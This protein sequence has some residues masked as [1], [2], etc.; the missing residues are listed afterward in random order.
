MLGDDATRALT[1]ELYDRSGGNPLFLEELAELVGCGGEPLQLPDSLRALVAARLDE[2]PVDQR[3]MLDNAAVLGSSGSYGGAGEFGQA[4]GQNAAARFSTRSPT[5]GCWR[6]TAVGG[7]SARP[8]SARSRTTPSPRPTVLVATS[9]WPR[10][11][12]TRHT[13]RGGPTCWPTTGRRRRS[14]PASSA[15]ASRASPATWSTRRCRRCWR[16]RPTTS[17]VSTPAPPSSRWRGRSR[18]ATASSTGPTRRSLVLTRAAAWVELRQFPEAEAD[19]QAVVDEAEAEGDRGCLA[20]ARAVRAEI[21]RLTG[22]YEDART[23]LAAAA[24]LLEDLGARHELAGV[25]RAWGMNSIF[26]GDFED[27]EVHLDVAE[28]LYD[29]EGDRRGRAWVDQHR[30]WVSFVRGDVDAADARLTAAASTLKEMGDRGGVAWA[31]GLLAYVRLFQGRFAEAEDLGRLVVEEAAERGDQWAEAM[32]MTL[33]A[34]LA[35]WGGRIDE[36]ARR[37]G[38][39]QRIFRV[40]GDRYGEIQ[41]ATTIARTLAAQGLSVDALRTAE[42]AVGL[43]TPIG[44]GTLAQS[45]TASVAMYAGPSS[46][47]IAHAHLALD[48]PDVPPG[49]GYD[50]LVTLALAHLQQ[51]RVD[52]AMTYA[53]RAVAV[54]PDHPNGTQCLALVTAATGRPEEAAP[55]PSRA[56]RGHL[57]RP[58]LRRGGARPGRGAAGQG[59]GHDRRPGG[60][61]RAH[62]RDDDAAVPVLA[63]LARCEALTVIGDVARAAGAQAEADRR[64]D[65]LDLDPRPWQV[66]FRLVAGGGAKKDRRP[67]PTCSPAGPTLTERDHGRPVG[68]I[69]GRFCPPHLGHSRPHHERRRAGRP[70]RG[71]R[72]HA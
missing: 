71:V 67:E 33:Q 9:A 23:E 21:A 24:A 47:A 66:A 61:R 38:E 2:L 18:S 28:A 30:A 32:L 57:P 46:R 56:E 55:W 41:A 51:G 63:E 17:T 49:F 5:P 22:R 4:L 69:V 3:A 54:R 72:Q 65:V 68:L 36:A 58:L 48:A 1:N 70:A 35:L 53:E 27:A 16:P 13:R 45:V 37:A 44:Q 14:W 39:A 11:W 62:R 59:P 19:L 31:L 60:A 20:R 7:G 25:Q 26:A 29:A 43:A 64:A 6:S 15:G 10:P 50:A 40:I 42:E 12:S 52:E 8:A 34:L